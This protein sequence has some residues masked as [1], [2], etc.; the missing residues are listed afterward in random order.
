VIAA[1]REQHMTR[2]ILTALKGLT[3]MAAVT[4][5]VALLKYA[6]VLERLNLK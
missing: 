2:P 6:F 3:Y 1:K 5:G 4:T